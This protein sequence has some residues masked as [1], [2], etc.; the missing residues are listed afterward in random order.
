M[1]KHIHIKPEAPEIRGFCVVCGKNPQKKRTKN[2]YKPIC[3]S[4]SKRLYEPGYKILIAKCKDKK[5]RPYR[6]HVKAL[7]VLC[8]FTPEHKCQLDVDHID[9]NH[10]NNDPNNLQTLCANC[11]RLKT[12]KERKKKAQ[13]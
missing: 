5:L 12:H 4:C 8:G 11:H 3:S 7:C 9:G 10:H 6:Q 1:G 13:C 2:K